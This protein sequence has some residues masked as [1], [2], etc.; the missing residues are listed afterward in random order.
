MAACRGSAMA[1]LSFTSAIVPED[2]PHL[3]YI[4]RGD[5]CRR[6]EPKV[7]PFRPGFPS[8]GPMPSQDEQHEG[9][10]GLYFSSPNPMTIAARQGS[11]LDGGFADLSEPSIILLHMTMGVI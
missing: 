2:H 4:D 10:G 3:R 5:D 7:Q 6:A 1:G 11:S 8:L 9:L